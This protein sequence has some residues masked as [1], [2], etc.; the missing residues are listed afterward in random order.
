MEATEEA[1]DVKTSSEKVSVRL[2]LRANV[3]KENSAPS[4]TVHERYEPI[5]GKV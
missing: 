3:W 2:Q 5:A 4:L 1:I